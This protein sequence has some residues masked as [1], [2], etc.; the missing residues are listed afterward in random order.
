MMGEDEQGISIMTLPDHPTVVEYLTLQ[1]LRVQNGHKLVDKNSAVSGRGT[2]L[3]G[4][5]SEGS[6]TTAPF[7]NY[8]NGQVRLNYAT[9]LNPHAGQGIRH[10]KGFQFRA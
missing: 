1:A 5:L 9:K 10:T 3:A 8:R 6:A 7:G 4:V 2:W